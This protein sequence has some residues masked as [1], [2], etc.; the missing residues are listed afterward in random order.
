MQSKVCTLSGTTQLKKLI[1]IRGIW[2][3][4]GL[5]MRETPRLFQSI[6]SSHY[7]VQSAVLLRNNFLL[8][9]KQW[10]WYLFGLFN[11]SSYS[12]NLRL[13]HE[14][15]TVL[16]PLA[17]HEITAFIRTVKKRLIKDS[18]LCP[19]GVEG[20]WTVGCSRGWSRPR[21]RSLCLPP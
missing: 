12:V 14:I 21:T 19:G 11:P 4:K 17:L 8:Q 15:D 9:E 10:T 2:G 18:R 6:L 5:D 13:K 16:K 20:T 1:S 7:W 3:K